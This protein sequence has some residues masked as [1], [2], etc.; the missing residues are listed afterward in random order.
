MPKLTITGSEIG[1]SE[2]PA[3]VLGNDGYNANQDILQRHRDARNKVE[4]IDSHKRKKNALI[5][6]DHLEPSVANWALD[7]LKFINPSSEIDMWEPKQ[8]FT[9]PEGKMGASIDR[10][11]DVKK[12]P[13]IFV[14]DE[15]EFVF[16]G[17]GIV[18]IKTD[19]YHQDRL[20]PSWVIQVHHQF[21]CSGL[22]WGIVACLSQKGQ[23]NL[24]PI[25]INQNLCKVIIQKVAEF[26]EILDADKDYPPIKEDTKEF[27]DIKKALPKTNHDF[28]TLCEN[29]T[30]ASQEERKWKRAKETAKQAI[31]DAMDGLQITHAKYDNYEIISDMVIKNRTKQVVTEDK[32]E[33]HKFSVKEKING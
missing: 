24:Y 23:L 8:A 14:R 1:S 11:I 6:G 31:A 30:H 17:Q 18:E 13:V 25:T 27:V 7:E 2:T 4:R 12:Q 5:R 3:I 20:R 28:L 15:Q 33:S 9:F 26:W 19:F 32:Y 22:D 21:I 16:E 29:F 10:I